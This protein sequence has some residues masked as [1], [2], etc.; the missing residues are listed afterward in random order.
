MTINTSMVIIINLGLLLL[1]ALTFASYVT[2]QAAK[3]KKR[4]IK[5]L[6]K[7][8]DQIEEQKSELRR[9][10]IAKK[11][12][13]KSNDS[14]VSELSSSLDNSQQAL[15]DLTDLQQSQSEVIKSI[16]PFLDTSSDSDSDEARELKVQLASL[17]AQ[18]MS[19][20]SL[21]D[22]LKKDLVS[23]RYRMQSLEDK[24]TSRRDDSDRLRVL[25]ALESKSQ[26]ENKD[27]CKKVEQQ[28]QR[29]AKYLKMEQELGDLRHKNRS[30]EFESQAQENQIEQLAAMLDHNQAN[31]EDAATKEKEPVDEELLL[32]TQKA[33]EDSE[34]NL[35]RSIR[36][37][38]FIETQFLEVLASLEHATDLEAELDRAKKEYELLEGHYLSL[39]ETTSAEGSADDDSVSDEKRFESMDSFDV[40]STPK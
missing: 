1:I 35:A 7:A 14:L 6:N 5:A 26:Q 31:Q 40:G 37:K 28:A 4:L 22:G 19:S 30:M 16:Q 36:E 23:S 33:L 3:T 20:T 38:D 15:S 39:V 34:D 21:V 8:R 18:A 2:A 11:E 24:L 9:L 13:E 12:S 10:R 27:L 25:Q 29:L 32:K 17:K